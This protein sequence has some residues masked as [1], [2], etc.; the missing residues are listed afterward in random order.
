MAITATV[1]KVPAPS[2]KYLA[3]VWN[4]CSRQAGD[5]IYK[6]VACFPTKGAHVPFSF[7]AHS[8]NDYLRIVEK[9]IAC[10]GSC[11]GIAGSM[12]DFELKRHHTS[13][14][15]GPIVEAADA[16]KP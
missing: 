16:F 14:E 13:Y 7:E 15:A 8:E 3:F 5:G 11:K 2:N 9:A 6:M 4:T 10:D 1:P 12:E